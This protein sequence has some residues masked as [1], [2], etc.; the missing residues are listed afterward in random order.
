MNREMDIIE[1][2]SEAKETMDSTTNGFQSNQPKLNDDKI[3]V[4]LM[5]LKRS[6][7]ETLRNL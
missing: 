4:I 5:T 7:D 1:A 3:Q 6:S 2:Q